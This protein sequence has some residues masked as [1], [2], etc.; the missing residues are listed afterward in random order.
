MKGVVRGLSQAVEECEE[1]G[2]KSAHNL[3]LRLSGIINPNVQGGIANYEKVRRDLKK[4][5]P[6]RTFLNIFYVLFR[7]FSRKLSSLIETRKKRKKSTKSKILSRVWWVKKFSTRIRVLKW[8]F[9]RF[10]YSKKVYIFMRN[11]VP[12]N[13]EGFMRYSLEILKNV[14]NTLKRITVKNLACFPP[15]PRSISFDRGRWPNCFRWTALL[16]VSNSSISNLARCRNEQANEREEKV[17]CK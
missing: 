15:M 3:V 17:L 9:Y 8:R 16:M 13:S 12:K 11:I 5:V 1:V 14:K 2:E 7:R 4:I 10:L 6:F